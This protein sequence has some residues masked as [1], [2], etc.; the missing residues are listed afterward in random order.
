V[1]VL[2]RAACRK[3][4]CLLTQS[5]LLF[6]KPIPSVAFAEVFAFAFGIFAFAL[7]F[8]VLWPLAFLAC[9]FAKAFA[10]TF[11]FITA[12]AFA[13]GIVAFCP[14]GVHHH[15]PSIQCICNELSDDKLKLEE[16]MQNTQRIHAEYCLSNTRGRNSKDE[17]G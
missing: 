9:G 8:G 5:V 3:Y 14:C 12:F 15:V 7:A 2:Q 13:C 10:F 16:Y 6:H 1:D 4:N 11:T 17:T